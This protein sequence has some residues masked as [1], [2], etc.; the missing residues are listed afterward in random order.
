MDSRKEILRQTLTVL[1]GEILCCGIMIAIFA[2]AGALDRTVWIGS[3]VGLVLAVGNFFLMAVSADAA[4]DR[5]VNEDVQGGKKL[6]TA[7]YIFRLALIFVILL[8]LVR[9]GV[10]NAIASIVPL[11]LIR[12]ILMVA[13]F[14]GKSSKKGGA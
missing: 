5:A 8:L 1:A 6:M 9:S 14:I 10:C 2:L 4:A 11:A 13:E 7:S 3:A 12:W